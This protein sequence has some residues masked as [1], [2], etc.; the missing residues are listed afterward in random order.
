MDDVEEDI[1]RF[2][3]KEEEEEMLVEGERICI[4]E[5]RMEKYEGGEWVVMEEDKEGGWNRME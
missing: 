2:N 3:R 5:I 1:G 4:T